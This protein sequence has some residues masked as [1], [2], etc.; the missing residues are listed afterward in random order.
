VIGWV[1][2]QGQWR[3][4]YAEVGSREGDVEKIYTSGSWAETVELLERYGVTY[5]YVGSLERSTYT[6]NIEKFDRSL[7]VLFEQGT[8]KI[9]GYTPG[10]GQ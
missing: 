1:F 4:G 2:H 6:V 3:G 5:I 9:Y 8:V 10:S 7:P